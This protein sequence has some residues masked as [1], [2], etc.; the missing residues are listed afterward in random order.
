MAAKIRLNDDV[1]KR[2]TDLTQLHPSVRD[3]VVKVMAELGR[4]NIPFRVFEA[5]RSPVRQRWLYAQGRSRKGAKVT[6]ADAWSS[7]HQYG[8]AVDF[9]L[10]VDG[11]WS[12]DDSGPRAAW[13]ARLH[14]IG[15]KHGLRP[16]TNEKPHLEIANW[17]MSDLKAGRYPPGGDRSWADALSARI[18]AWGPGAPPA[19][20]NLPVPAILAIPVSPAPACDVKPMANA[21]A[22][23]STGSGAGASAPV[24][25]ALGETIGRL[26]DGRKSAIGIVGLMLTGLLSPGVA[27][28]ADG[29]A[30]LVTPDLVKLVPALEPLMAVSPTLQPVFIALL[31]WGALGKAEKWLQPKP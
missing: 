7:F 2:E 1:N 8:L 31:I 30:G 10:F 29:G 28:N 3:A 16:L 19:P 24:A 27:P 6:G 18:A 25:N 11:A 13:W 23:A 26:L 12:W 20:R 17:K 9:V 14:E 15:Q 22:A 5:V 21:L 4:E